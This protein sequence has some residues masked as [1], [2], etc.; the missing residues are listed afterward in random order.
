VEQREWLAQQRPGTDT[1]LALATALRLSGPPGYAR[2]EAALLPL[3]NQSNPRALIELAELYRAAENRRA[4]RQVLD[5][6]LQA[7]PRGADDYP[8]VRYELG[9][10]LVD[11]E[12]VVEAEI[13]FEAAL[14]AEPRHI[15]SLLALAQINR[16]DPALA[17]RYYRSALDVGDDDPAV[18]RRIGGEL[19]GYRE[20]ELAAQAYER[21]L[22]ISPDDAQ[23]HYGLALASLRQEDLA[24]AESEARM[25]IVAAGGSYP[26]AQVVLGDVALE[27]GDLAAAVEEYNAA[28]RQNDGLVPAYLGLGRAAARE[29]RWAVATGH[30]RNAVARDPEASEAHLWLGEALMRD[31]NNNPS[32]AAESYATA[33]GRRPDYAEA[34]LGL[35]QAQIQLGQVESAGNSLARAIALRPDYAEAFLVRGRLAEQQADENRAIE[36]YGR[37][38]AA[39]DRLAEPHYR[40]AL[41]M[42]RADRLDDARGD[43]ERAVELQPNF[44]EAH[45]WLGRANFA[46]ERYADAVENFRQAAAQ[47][48]SYAEARYYQGLAEERAG[49]VGEALLS[50]RAAAE[51]GTGTIWLEEAQKALAR[52]ESQ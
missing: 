42:I 16:A 33:I 44:P 3:A 12:N 20:F 28:L 29:G 32:A 35:A 41:L 15:P 26:E 6:A 43:L 10:L 30:F 52:L 39:G 19:L 2:A 47:Q 45:Y 5:R 46:Q 14:S 21:A 40:R 17:T 37:A 7:A 25:A 48:P 9:R 49:R 4:A 1:T 38:I 8:D 23:L 13:E 22:V 50:Y 36:D 11:E 18:L 27:R 51:Q 31:P 24:R 34:Y